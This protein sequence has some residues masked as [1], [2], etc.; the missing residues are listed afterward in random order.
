MKTQ[1]I[2]SEDENKLFSIYEES[3]QYLENDF[4]TYDDAKQ[5]CENQNWLIVESFNV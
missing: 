2:I 3:G 1:V 4:E 5:Y